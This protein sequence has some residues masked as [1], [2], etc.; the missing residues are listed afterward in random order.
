VKGT[1]IKAKVER[2]SLGTRSAK[3]A[4]RSVSNITARRIVARAEQGWAVIQDK[5]R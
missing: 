2:S 5:S 1:E 4:R 3:A